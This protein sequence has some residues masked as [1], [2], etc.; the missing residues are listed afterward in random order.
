[1]QYK[2]VRKPLP[3]IARA[4]N[5]ELIVEGTVSR[6]GDQ[7][8]INAQLVDGKNDIHL[9]AQDFERDLRNLLNLESDV[10]QAIAR[11]IRVEL[12][13]EDASRLVA[14]HPVNLNAHDAYLRGRYQWNKKTGRARTRKRSYQILTMRL[15]TREWRIPTSS[16]MKSD[17][18][19][20]QR[21]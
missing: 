21:P 9:W 16:W 2:Q 13:K 3:E 19:R 10:A 7:V 15:P 17:S 5:V 11:E 18:C 8:R 6:S 1:M 20:L 4:L 12:T 14:S